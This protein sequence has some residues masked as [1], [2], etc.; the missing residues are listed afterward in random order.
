MQLDH[1]D[2]IYALAPPEELSVEE[3]VIQTAGLVTSGKARSWGLLNW[4]AEQTRDAHRIAATESVSTPVAAQLPYSIVQTSPVE[5]DDMTEALVETGTGLV[6]SYSLAAGVLTG[7]YDLDDAGG[8][9]LDRLAEERLARAV[10]ASRQLRP[11]ADES[12]V[13]LVTLAYAFVLANPLVDSA[14]TGATSADH[15]R[16]NA[17]AIRRAT[18]I[19]PDVLEQVRVV[20]AS[21]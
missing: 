7:K 12:G 15:I 8:R 21:V 10:E 4:S 18:E 1:V 16:Q 11:I 2:I 17:A 9:A 14:M 13:D 19:D 3:A 6:S 20:A 5:D